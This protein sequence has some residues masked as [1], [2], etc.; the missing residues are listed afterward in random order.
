MRGEKRNNPGPLTVGNKLERVLYRWM[1]SWA[2]AEFCLS[3]E[4]FEVSKS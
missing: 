2:Q 3:K 4:E 1:F